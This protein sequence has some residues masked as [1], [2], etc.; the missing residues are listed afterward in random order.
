MAVAVAATVGLAVT[1]FVGV[2]LAVGEG[3]AVAVW[4][5][6]IDGEGVAEADGMTAGTAVVMTVVDVAVADGVWGTAVGVPVA[7]GL[8]AAA[9]CRLTI[10]P[11]ASSSKNPINTSTYHHR[12]QPGV[13]EVGVRGGKGTVVGGSVGSS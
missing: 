4:V 6:V 1:E 12:H 10:K 9:S 7:K 3:L 13:K 11:A 8:M 5:G 2:W